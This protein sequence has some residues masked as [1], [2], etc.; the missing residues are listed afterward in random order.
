[1]SFTSLLAQQQSR[2]NAACEH[3]RECN[4]KLNH[5]IDQITA[6][7]A[8]DADAVAKLNKKLETAGN[9]TLAA[10]QAWDEEIAAIADIPETD[11]EPARTATMADNESM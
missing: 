10:M 9:E 4:D 5:L 8:W 6:A 7:D 1:M 3:Y 2:I 11:D